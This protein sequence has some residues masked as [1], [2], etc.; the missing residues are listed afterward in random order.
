M[1]PGGV[2]EHRAGRELRYKRDPPVPAPRIWIGATTL[3]S[4]PEARGVSLLGRGAKKHLP[5]LGKKG[6][7]FQ[8][9]DFSTQT[10]ARDSRRWD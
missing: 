1:V 6:W 9:L 5:Y 10:G 3:F 8:S 4:D 7:G 2:A